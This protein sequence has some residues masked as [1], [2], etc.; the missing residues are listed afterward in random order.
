MKIE[1]N[2]VGFDLSKLSLEDLIKVYKDIV[3]FLQFLDD[4]KFDIEEKGSDR[5]E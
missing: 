3:D 2:K 1:N 4:N 5:D